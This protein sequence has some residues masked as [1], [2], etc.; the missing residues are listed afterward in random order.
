MRGSMITYVMQIGFV[1]VNIHIVNHVKTRDCIVVA[2][3]VLLNF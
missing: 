2:Y 1:I 3:K